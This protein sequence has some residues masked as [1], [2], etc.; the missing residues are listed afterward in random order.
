MVAVLLT[1]SDPWAGTQA[2]VARPPLKA[3]VVKR[4]D[5]GALAWPGWRIHGDAVRPGRCRR[6][7]G[8]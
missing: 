1:F 8:R 3:A 7:E 5:K 6:F 2:L 4:F